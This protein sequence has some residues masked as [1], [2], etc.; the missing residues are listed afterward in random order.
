MEYGYITTTTCGDVIY[1]YSDD[2][3]SNCKSVTL[4][5]FA[6][7]DGELTKVI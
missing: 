6:I 5:N 1:V 4:H 3:T 2:N 7:V